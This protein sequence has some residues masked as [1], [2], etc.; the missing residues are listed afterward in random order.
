MRNR[1]F[2]TLLRFLDALRAMT[3]PQPHELVELLFLYSLLLSGMEDTA[4]AAELAWLAYGG[5]VRSL[6]SEDAIY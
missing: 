6:R 2:R 5:T 3:I 4:T 1:P